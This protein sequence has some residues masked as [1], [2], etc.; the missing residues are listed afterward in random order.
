MWGRVTRNVMDRPA[1]FVILS[2]GLLVACALPY[3]DLNRG[4]A[5][6]ETQPPSDVRTA[7][8]LLTADFSAGLVAPVEIVVDGDA[9]TGG[10]S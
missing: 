2:A 4:L 5:G 3:F 7:Y 10:S 1:L 8:Q 9:R 6:I